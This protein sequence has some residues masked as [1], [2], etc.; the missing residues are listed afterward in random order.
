MKEELGSQFAEFPLVVT[1]Q[2]GYSGLCSDNHGDMT[3]KS[4]ELAWKKQLLKPGCG[5]GYLRAT[6]LQNCIYHE[7]PRKWK[8]ER[9]WAEE[10]KPSPWPY[11]P[12]PSTHSTIVKNLGGRLFISLH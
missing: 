6:H 3:G 7:M 12:R 9:Y 8:G 1:F 5:K 2:A 4:W 10:L 11:Q